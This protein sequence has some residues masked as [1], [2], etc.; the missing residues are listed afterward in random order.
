MV[1]DFRSINSLNSEY[2]IGQGEPVRGLIALKDRVRLRATLVAQAVI[3]LGKLLLTRAL[4]C[5]DLKVHISY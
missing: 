3:K 1:T 4:D 2:S 5:P